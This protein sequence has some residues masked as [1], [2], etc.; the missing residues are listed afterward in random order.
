MP[1]HTGQ[2]F[3][4]GETPSATKWN[5]LW[6]NDYALADGTGIEDDAID[7]RHYV[8]G[9]IDGEHLSTN[10][11]WA[12]TGWTP[13]FTASGSM[14]VTATTINVARYK[15]IGKTLHFVIDATLTLGGTTSNSIFFTL[16]QNALLTSVNL[17]IGAGFIDGVTAWCQMNST[18][19]S[20]ITRRYDGGNI[21]TGSGKTV[22]YFGT[23]E[24]A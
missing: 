7:S 12:W 17:P 20:V 6:E 4:F 22:R 10:S 23:L 11:T 13:T 3:T 15:V 14:T 1:F 16:P 21:S 5:Y 2:T 19:T 8:D 18:Q 24:L 9:S